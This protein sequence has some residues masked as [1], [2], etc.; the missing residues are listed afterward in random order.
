MKRQ[1]L[2]NEISL[3]IATVFLIVAAF[4]KNIYILLIGLIMIGY[5]SNKIKKL[6]ATKKE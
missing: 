3:M 5:S 6:K 4:Q 2:I 1:I